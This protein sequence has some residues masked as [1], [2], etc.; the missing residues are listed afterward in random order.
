MHRPA[1]WL[2]FFCFPAKQSVKRLFF[3]KHFIRYFHTN[4][5]QTMYLFSN[6]LIYSGCLLH[7]LYLKYLLFYYCKQPFTYFFAKYLYRHTKIFYFHMINGLFFQKYLIQYFSHRFTF[8]IFTPKTRLLFLR[9]IY[10]EMVFTPHTKY[11]TCTTHTNANATRP[12]GTSPIIKNPTPIT[13]LTIMMTYAFV[14]TVM[15]SPRT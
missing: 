5:I 8:S 4:T 7:F 9:K 12:T 13:I 6:A 1:L 11:T 14:R 10:Y 3:A 2:Y 15:P